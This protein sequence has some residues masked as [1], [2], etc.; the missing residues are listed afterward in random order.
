MRVALKAAFALTLLGALFGRGNADD[1]PASAAVEA[2]QILD[3]ALD[4][5]RALSAKAAA[6]RLRLAD[7]EARQRVAEERLKKHAGTR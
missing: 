1:T 7:L 2:K 3:A 5:H 6:L 4:E